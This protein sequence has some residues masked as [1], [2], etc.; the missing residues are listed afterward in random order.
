[1]R[2]LLG[3]AFD[4]TIADVFHAFC[5]S[6]AHKLFLAIAQLYSGK[7]NTWYGRRASFNFHL[8]SYI[9]Y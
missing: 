7:L 9:R 6:N 2:G 5:L 8:N 3:K 4:F 1:M